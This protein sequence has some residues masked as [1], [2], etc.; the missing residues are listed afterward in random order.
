MVSEPIS[1]SFL[2]ATSICVHGYTGLDVITIYPPLM[3]MRQVQHKVDKQ[4]EPHQN[5]VLVVFKSYEVR[6]LMAL[7]QWSSGFLIF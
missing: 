7:V 4:A 2:H 6:F 5:S 1:N 3:L